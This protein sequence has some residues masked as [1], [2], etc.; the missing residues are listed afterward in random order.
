MSIKRVCFPGSFDPIT[1]GHLDIIER[2]SV[3]YDE[4][5]IAIGIHPDKSYFLP[6]DTRVD[7]I[8]AECQAK[9]IDAQVCSYQGATVTWAKSQGIKL[10]VRG[11]RNAS[12]Q[13]SESVNAHVNRDNGIDTIFLLTDPAL[14][15][16][17]SSMVRKVLAAGLDP[18]AYLGPATA[19]YLTSR[20]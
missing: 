16:I 20:I 17:S 9:G 11:L 4:L 6:L 7:L 1:K 10:L 5:I 14:S 13:A 18:S 2:A 8:T 19:T 15:H 12:D 3:L